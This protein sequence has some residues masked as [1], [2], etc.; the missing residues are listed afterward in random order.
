MR[1]ETSRK[2]VW[3]AS[4]LGL[5]LTAAGVLQ[6]L[7]LHR[8]RARLQAMA[9]PPPMRLP[10]ALPCSTSSGNAG[11]FYAALRRGDRRTV[12]AMLAANEITMIRKGTV[13]SIVQDRPMATVT[14]QADPQQTVS[15]F[16]PADVVPAIE[17]KA[18]R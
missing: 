15:C 6:A 18:Y 4:I 13:L 1:R 8:Q 14:T 17:R 9:G 10:F 2:P 11:L 7:H 16:I 5:A 3:A 12:T